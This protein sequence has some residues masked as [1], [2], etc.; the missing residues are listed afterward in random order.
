MGDRGKDRQKGEVGKNGGCDKK[1]VERAK[2]T[3]TKSGLEREVKKY[4]YRYRENCIIT[5]GW[6]Y[7]YGQFTAGTSWKSG[8]FTAKSPIIFRLVCIIR[9]SL[10]FPYFQT[11]ESLKAYSVDKWIV[12]YLMYNF[13]Q[14]VKIMSMKAFEQDYV[15]P[16]V[17]ITVV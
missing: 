6:M 2:K 7:L 9:K 10:L 13:C 16:G 5:P 15:C 4:R 8:V 17:N 11:N 14:N 3:K 12:Y 1:Q